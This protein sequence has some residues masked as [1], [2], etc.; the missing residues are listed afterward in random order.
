VL[1]FIFIGL[2]IWPTVEVLHK[3][4]LRALLRGNPHCNALTLS[5]T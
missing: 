1:L 5:G 3:S 2:S 4:A